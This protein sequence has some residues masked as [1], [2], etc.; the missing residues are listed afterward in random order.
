MTR[1][2]NTDLK[3]FWQTPDE[4]LDYI[5][6]RISLDPCASP[7]SFIGEVN[8]TIQ[9]PGIDVNT[10]EDVITHYHSVE[11]FSG[12]GPFAVEKETGD[13]TFYETDSLNK[14]WHGVVFVNPPFSQKN[15][16]LEH[17]IEQVQEG[18]TKCAFV[19]TPDSTDVKSWWHGNI[20]EHADYIWFSRGRIAYINPETGEKANL[21]TFGT[22]LSIFGE[23]SESTLSNL[24][25]KGQLVETYEP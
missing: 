25:E 6:E 1:R 4:L 23:P 8:F 22:A 18:N 15:E 2:N 19:V 24:S 12:D 17:T 7:N 20:A 9:S 10:R 21:P 14:D 3:D 16:F 13:I 5:D 11:A